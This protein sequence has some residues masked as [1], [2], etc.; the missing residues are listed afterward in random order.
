MAGKNQYREV[1]NITN[2]DETTLCD[3]MKSL[4]KITKSIETIESQFD[5]HKK[6]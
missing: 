1:T 2:E 3:V 4:W 6:R 5:K